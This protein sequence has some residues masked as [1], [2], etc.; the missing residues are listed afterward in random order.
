L[1][2]SA[3]FLIVG[4]RPICALIYQ[5]GKFGWQDSIN[6]AAALQAYAVGLIFFGLVRL[7]AQVFYA[8]KNAATPVRIS[9]I[10]V[11]INI[12]I[13]LLLMKPLGFVGL[14]LAPGISAAA[15]FAMLTFTIRRK[16]GRP[17]YSQLYGIFL[18]TT[19]AGGAG[20]IVTYLLLRYFHAYESYSGLI[21]TT[22]RIAI[23]FIAGIGIFAGLGMLLGIFKR[24]EK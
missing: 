3:L 17:D 2:P 15:N 6:A 23:A 4:A 14:A 7:A 19:I 5:H 8:H 18:K 16:I 12:V 21:H 10:T 1:W 9:M 24:N 22:P 11:A 13:S 20:C